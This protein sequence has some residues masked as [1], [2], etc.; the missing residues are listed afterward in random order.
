[1]ER[2]Q[3]IGGVGDDHEVCWRAAMNAESVAIGASQGIGGGIGAW[4]ALRFVRWFIEFLAK[5]FDLR[6]ARLDQRELAIEEKFNARLRTVE[7]ELDRYRRATMRLVN[8]LATQ[9]PQDPV[10]AEVAEILRSAVP[11]PKDDLGGDVMDRLNEIP[12]T[13][14]KQ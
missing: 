7:Q 12:G 3:R 5:R 13:K 11:M 2:P 4:A 10:L 6:A 1:M 8:R 9:L 14:D